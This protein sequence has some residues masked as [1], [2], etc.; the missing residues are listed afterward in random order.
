MTATRPI[1]ALFPL[2]DQAGGGGG[3]CAVERE[4]MGGRCIGVV[5]FLGFVDLLFLDEDAAADVETRL[6]G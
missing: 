2:R 4:E 1:L 6:P 3:R 5:P